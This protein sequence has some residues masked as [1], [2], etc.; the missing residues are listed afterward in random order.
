MTS[1]LKT[2]MLCNFIFKAVIFFCRPNKEKLRVAESTMRLLLLLSDVI[3]GEVDFNL[4]VELVILWVTAQVQARTLH[5]YL[6]PCKK[7]IILPVP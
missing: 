1:G 2:N 6:L 3:H 4:N 5:N 7:S